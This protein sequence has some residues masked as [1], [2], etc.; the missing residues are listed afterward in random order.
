MDPQAMAAAMAIPEYG[1]NVAAN[2][3]KILAALD[4]AGI[5]DHPTRVAAAATVLVETGR[6]EPIEEEGDWSYF[7][8]E[9]GSYE[10]RW[11]GRGYIQLSWSYNYKHYGDLLGMDLLGHPELAMD[12]SIGAKVLAAY[13]RATGVPARAAAG[14]WIAV[15]EAVNGGTNGWAVFYPAVLN[16]AAL[17][18]TPTRYVTRLVEARA[19]KPSPDHS[20]PALAQVRAGAVVAFTPAADGRLTTPHWV[21]CQ[22]VSGNRAD[23]KD[24]KG[25]A[26]WFLRGDLL[27]TVASGAAAPRGE[28]AP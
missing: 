14:N 5:N 6:F 17:P 12:P 13:F 24:A 19:I 28:V 4:W 18:D 15:R 20:S 26:G 8:N 25:L 1:G 7:V 11:H 3:P 27:T 21:H 9:F 16:L 22:I 2:W 10:A 23:G